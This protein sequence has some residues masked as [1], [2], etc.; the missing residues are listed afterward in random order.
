MSDTFR[1]TGGTINRA[2]RTSFGMPRNP[3]RDS[4]RQ[5]MFR[6]V[7]FFVETD[8]RASGRRISLHE[9]PKRD[10]PYAEDMGQRA[11]RHQ[12]TAY[13]VGPNYIRVR[14]ALINAC[15]I[16]GPGMLVHPLL[17]EFNVVCDS[18]IVTESRERGGF[19]AFELSFTQAGLPGDSL[20]SQA[21]QDVVKDAAATTDKQTSSALDKSLKPGGIGHA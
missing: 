13:L 3:W 4:W 2:G 20:I 10:I 1:L 8:S 21:T 15:E 9:Y 16:E 18:Y 17:G 5:A 12:F 19:C 6:A 14:D 7:P 11:V